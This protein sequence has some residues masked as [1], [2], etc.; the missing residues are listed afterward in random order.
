MGRYLSCRSAAYAV[1]LGQVLGQQ[2][3]VAPA[4]DIPEA[5]SFTYKLAASFQLDVGSG[6]RDGAFSTEGALTHLVESGLG[7]DPLQ[8]RLAMDGNHLGIGEQCF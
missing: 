6:G 8:F 2:R 1:E 4:D 5:H 7:S 3:G